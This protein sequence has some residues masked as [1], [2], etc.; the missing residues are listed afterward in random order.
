[1]PNEN[2][3]NI[4]RDAD[5]AVTKLDDYITTL[6]LEYADPETAYAMILADVAAQLPELGKDDYH[7]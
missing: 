2:Y 4:E 7:V 3:V 1:M 6:S 5:A